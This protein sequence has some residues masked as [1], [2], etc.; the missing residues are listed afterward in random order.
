MFEYKAHPYRDTFGKLNAEE[1]AS[2]QE[3]FSDVFPEGIEGFVK[4]AN[5]KQNKYYF[6]E[7][8]KI[9]DLEYWRNEICGNKYK[10][11]GER[12]LYISMNGFISPKSARVSNLLYINVWAIDVDYK[13]TEEFKLLKPEEMYERHIEPFCGTYYL[14]RPTN[15]E[16][17]NQLRLIYI[18]D[19]YMGLTKE[20]REK[21]INLVRAIKGNIERRL[22]EHPWSSKWGIDKGMNGVQSYVRVPYSESGNDRV[23]VRKVGS[24]VNLGV[25]AEYYLSQRPQEKDG[26]EKSKEKAKSNRKKMRSQNYIKYKHINED[27]LKDLE[28]IQKYYNTEGGGIGHREILCHLYRM[29]SF[30]LTGSDFEA[31][32]R[33]LEFNKN[34]VYPLPEHE[35]DVETRYSKRYKPYKNKT[36]LAA[37]DISEDTAVALELTIIASMDQYESQK[38]Y[39]KRKRKEAEKKGKTKHAKM[40]K[41]KEKVIDLHKKGYTKSEIAKKLGVSLSTV[42][43]DLKESD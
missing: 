2:M 3:F 33:M 15:I 42:K 19:Q 11:F 1:L 14:P 20:S 30:L 37:L 43:R 7:A 36:F 31:R 25:L 29:H 23:K 24:K 38:R 6:F 39:Y 34:F 41:R 13:K 35:V 4:I 10:L 22:E 12:N 18:L 21:Q 17:G 40:E 32:R 16:T 28:K 27:R 9:R 8:S 5:L 26:K